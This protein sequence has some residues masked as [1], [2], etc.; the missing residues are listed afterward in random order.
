MQGLSQVI[1]LIQNRYLGSSRKYLEP[2]FLVFT[3][4]LKLRVVHIKKFKILVFSEMAQTI[5]IKICGFI[6]HSKPND[7]TLSTFPG[8]SLKLE[9]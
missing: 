3:L 2:S 8:K 5:L 1:N 9:K 4:T 7:M 6:V